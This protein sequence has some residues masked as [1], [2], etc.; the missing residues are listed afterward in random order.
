MS[1]LAPCPICGKQP[2]ECRL[3]GSNRIFFYCS[4]GGHIVEMEACETRE[5]AVRRWNVRHED[6]TDIG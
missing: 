1:K 3:V 4:G 6:D 2:K 5:E